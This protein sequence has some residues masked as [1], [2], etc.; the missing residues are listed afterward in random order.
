MGIQRYT[1]YAHY[2]YAIILHTWLA[3]PASSPA[4][5]LSLRCIDFSS[6]C[7]RCWCMSNTRRL[8]VDPLKPMA[9]RSERHDVMGSLSSHSVGHCSAGAI[10]CHVGL[11]NPHGQD[12]DGHKLRSRLGPKSLGPAVVAFN[13]AEH[14]TLKTKQT[15]KL[16]IWKCIHLGSFTCPAA[17]LPTNNKDQTLNSESSAAQDSQASDCQK[18][19]ADQSAH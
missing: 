2:L 9:I 16:T 5:S 7:R 6:T 14:A 10:C 13:Y 8:N 3:P 1:K 11:P 19:L 17:P 15:H 18:S 12:E 4:G